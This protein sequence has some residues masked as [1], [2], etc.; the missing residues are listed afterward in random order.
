MWALGGGGPTEAANDSGR[1]Y[2]VF[3]RTSNASI[4]LSAI[5]A[6]VGG[7]VINGQCAH[8]RSG[9]S[10]SGVGDVNGDGLADMIVGAPDSQLPGDS[11]RSYVVFG[12]TST[13]VINLSEVVA[14]SGGFV[15]NGES[16]VDESGFSVSGAGDVNGDGL[17]DLIVGAPGNDYSGG[18]A[19]R[20]YVVFG[21][22]SGQA[23]DLFAVAAGIG[24]FVIN[25]EST[26]HQSGR[27]V[28]GVGDYNGDGLAD[29][30]VGARLAA[31]SSQISTGRSYVVFGKTSGMAIDLTAVVKGFGGFVLDGQERQ[32]VFG[33]SVSGAGDVN[34]DGLADLIVGANSSDP[35]AISNAGRSYVIFGNTTGVAGTGTFVDQLGTSG[36]DRLTD[37]GQS[38]TLVGGAGPDILTATAASVLYGGSG[39]DMIYINQTMATALQSPMGISGNVSRL[40]RIDGG[41]GI[42]TLVLAANTRLDLTRVANSAA[43]DLE[44]SD[45]IAS[46]ERVDLSASGSALTLSAADV[47]ALAGKNSFNSSNG[48]SFLGDIVPRHQLLITGSAGTLTAQGE[49]VAAGMHT[50]IIGE[51]TVVW[52]WYNGERNTQLILMDNRVLPGPPVHLSAIAAGVGGFVINGQNMIDFSGYSVSGAGDVNGDGLSDLIVGAHLA[53][54]AAGFEAGRSYVVFGRTSGDAINL[55]AVVSGTGGFVIN[56]Q[57]DYDNAAY[58]VSGVGDVNGDGLS[59]LI[60]GAWKSSP[61]SNAEEAG[62]SYLVFGRTGGSAINLSA[63]AAGSGGFVINGQ[64]NSDYSGSSVSG[65]GDV[66]GDGLADLIV[67]AP[68]SN[69]SGGRSYVVFGRTTTRAV[70][71]SALSGSGGF[72]I[73]GQC[74]SDSSGMSVSSA[75]D[76]NGDG[77]SDLIVGAPYSNPLSGLVGGTYAGRSYVVFGRTAGTAINL[78]AVVAGSGG[79]VINGQSAYD[80]SGMSVSGAG[81]VNGDGLADL[82]VGAWLSDPA[83]GNW[84]GRT[85]VVFGRSAGTAINLSAVAA[86]S[87]GFVINGH[88]AGDQSGLS[89]SGAGDINGDGL[90]DLIV[91]APRSDPAAGVDAGRSYVVFGRASGAAI[92]LSAVALGQ[93]GF[94][95]NGQGGL[96]LTQDLSGVSV[97]NAGDVNGDGL[98]DLIVGAS[99]A[100]MS[101]GRSYVIFGS[102]SGAFG[103]TAVDWLGTSGEDTRSDNGVASTLV[104]G[105]GNDTLTAT[106]ASVLYG[107][108]G[109]DRFVID[110]AMIT[111]LQSPFGSGGNV[112][113]LARIDGGGGL[114]TLVLAGGGLTLDLTQIANQAGSSPDGGSR[115]DSIERIDLTGTGNNTL[116]LTARDVL[117]MSSAN[118]FA[119]DGRQQLLVQGNAGDTVDLADGS[120]IT[121]WKRASK[122]VTIDS[123]P[124]FEWE[125]STM[126]SVYV[127]ST[128]AV[129]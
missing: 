51:E 97:S 43:G 118:L 110:Q 127:Q 123:L 24:G 94:V 104:A 73:N 62:R 99:G 47:A 84:A 30:I 63:V 125:H 75:G 64:G 72:V 56:G 27:S 61:S 13:A 101:A 66:N 106:A 111:A 21:R 5:A 34:G 90:A 76:V 98:A 102:T 112:N 26:S 96:S 119:V 6:G 122:S 10:V 55:S 37:G 54:P 44:G 124:Y 115:I 128:L 20:S 103:Q 28:S 108:A 36:Q 42:D 32:D 52:R 114:D 58:S 120:G 4:D 22:T 19:G 74:S 87:G 67:G 105:A 25:G 29:L 68:G 35:A 53:D 60:V 49:W 107:G 17:A 69:D 23:I 46:I 100:N 45:R 33:S 50:R 70:N 129:I 92:D 40:S 81:D 77:L 31:D 117:D 86:G 18:N 12:K 57:C 91:G 82:I 39:S 89:V 14:G 116:K 11:G 1:T 3:G 121:G 59:D 85:Y 41:T 83:A 80:E 48:Y 15:I 16:P 126:A 93:G 79:F 65:A 71:L 95:I 9:Y 2:V 88:C 38:K 109:N 7:F 113:Q 78:S 8:D